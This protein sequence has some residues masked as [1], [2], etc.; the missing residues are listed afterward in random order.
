MFEI[1]GYRKFFDRL[2]LP[3]DTFYSKSSKAMWP[4]IVYG[5]CRQQ[6]NAF[7][8]RIYFPDDVVTLIWDYYFIADDLSSAVR[9]SEQNQGEEIMIDPSQE[10]IFEN[11]ILKDGQKVVCR[12]RDGARSRLTVLNDLTLHR[13]SSIECNWGR[14]VLIVQGNLSLRGD[15]S[16]SAHGDGQIFIKTAGRL[17]M[18]NALISTC[19]SNEMMYEGQKWISGGNVHLVVAKDMSVNEESIIR[20]GN[21]HIECE[22]L[23]ISA[24]SKLIS[25]RNN[26][27]LLAVD[28]IH[29]ERGS[30]ILFEP[31]FQA[32]RFV[33]AWNKI[34]SSERAHQLMVDTVHSDL[35]RDSLSRE[36]RF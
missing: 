2:P 26:I 36:L 16:I 25:R 24:G 14:L 6:D 20:S 10:L 31:L 21:I 28:H 7:P 22:D 35:G 23:G 15:S 34:L 9:D 18:T 32:N 3:I 30:G 1:S 27:D 19:S 11:L 8:E 13:G 4:M 17:T 33:L 5:Y 12:G 29:L